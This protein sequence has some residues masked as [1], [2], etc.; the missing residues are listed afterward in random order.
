M[1][2]K[3]LNAKITIGGAVSGSL[4][5][6]F[7][8]VQ[9]STTQI[10]SAIKHLSNEQRQLNE[11]M[12]RYGQNG[13][14]VD[15]LRT[16]YENIVGQVERLRRAQERLNRV[17]RASAENLAKRAE[18]RG[19]MLDT[20]A[21]GAAVAA[22]IKI[23]ADRESHAVGIAKQ[24]Q[25][26]RD[27]A[28]K[29]TPVF[30]QM[31]K[32][33]T[34][35]GHEIPLATNDLY[36]MAAAGLRMGVASNDILGFTRNTA[37]LAAALELDPGE[38]AERFAKLGTVF[39]LSQDQLMGLGDAINY[40]DDQTTAKGGEI[41]DFM[42]RVGGSAGLVK[43]TAGQVAAI[44][45]ALISM[46]ET[47]ETAGTSTAALFSKLAMGDK[48]TKAAREAFKEL[49]LSAGQMSKA[50]QKDAIGAMEMLFDRVRKLPEASRTGVLVD[51]FGQEHVGKI[52]KLVTGTK[53][54]A[55]ALEAV[56]G[57]ASKGSVQKE[58]QNTISTT[59]AQMVLLS[60]RMADVADNIG[61]VL[62]PS[63][64]DAASTIG[65]FTTVVAN[66]AQE[67][68]GLTKAVVGTAVALT[69]L[70]VAT[71]AGGYAFTFLKGGALMV[72]KGLAGA[73]AE[74]ALTATGARLL[75][76]SAAVAQG[77]VIGL[78]RALMMNPIGAIAAGIAVAGL[79]IYKNWDMVKAAAIG[80]GR[81][82]VEGLQPVSDAIST[83]R[84]A[85]HPLEPAFVAVGDAV[86]GV[87]NW[88][89]DL[90]TPTKHT[91]DQLKSA[92]DAG[93]TFGRVVGD[94]INFVLTP[95]T[96]LVDGFK[97]ISEHGGQIM[98]S[99]GAT[100]DKAKSWLPSWAGGTDDEKEAPKAPAGLVA[101]PAPAM[102]NRSGS[103]SYTTEQT[104]H[105][106][107]HAAPGMNEDALA[108]KVAE[109]LKRQQ[110]VRGRSMMTDGAYQP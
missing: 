105:F 22:P 57:E 5:G 106:T 73:R 60:N 109:T 94:A 64:N 49:G 7:G 25:G 11:A 89:S 85:L 3:K 53:E 47:A 96:A 28:G 80:F 20:V 43:I 40:L 18:L 17:E 30:W 66:F 10:G 87:F 91:A 68:P 39:K 110:A 84:Q 97:W 86:K 108:R 75:G 8:T 92:T 46:G 101:P 21:L 54:L 100:I 50:V 6:A 67:H 61:T 74:M 26:A 59:N 37:K 24:L 13:P 58:F 81:G 14:M 83:V 44:G 65:K 103:T 79:A 99:V 35:L 12:K 70:K 4:R 76:A 104:N 93:Q 31:R 15:R 48:N 90:L 78:G 107:I 34:D 16:R 56:N 19:Q 27:E 82:M 23:A 2:N 42:A 62:L 77:G 51:I 88:F 55:S 102:A 98:N 1:A 32:A 41:I 29:L 95:L 69:S 33:V 36:D 63:V 38:T 71:L 52:A 9:K 72:A 45:T